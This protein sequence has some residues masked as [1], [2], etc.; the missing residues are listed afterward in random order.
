MGQEVQPPQGM[1]EWREGWMDGWI[2]G[3]REGGRDGWM[4]G[5][6][7]GWMD[8]GMNRR[9]QASSSCSSSS[10]FNRH[11]DGMT[12]KQKKKSVWPEVM[13]TK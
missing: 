4:Q 1:D 8:E 11:S 9:K 7:E 12:R 2:D 10:S 13:R 3:C 6:R 5:G